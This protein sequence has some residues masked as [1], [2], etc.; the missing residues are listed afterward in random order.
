MNFWPRKKRRVETPNAPKS[1]PIEE[2]FLVSVNT[3]G[4]I[5]VDI[6]NSHDTSATICTMTF[7]ST[8]GLDWMVQE[9]EKGMAAHNAMEP[10]FDKKPAKQGS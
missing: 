9:L 2:W 7:N 8:H 1:R 10:S 4:Q 3:K 5:L 6:R